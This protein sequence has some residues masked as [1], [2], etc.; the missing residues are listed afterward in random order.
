MYLKEDVVSNEPTLYCRVTPTQMLLQA[1]LMDNAELFDVIAATTE[2]DPRSVEIFLQG[3]DRKQAYLLFE[4]PGRGSYRMFRHLIE[5][6]RFDPTI[7]E[8]DEANCHTVHATEEAG[9]SEPQATLVRDDARGWCCGAVPYPKHTL[10]SWVQSEVGRLEKAL[11]ECKT[12][13]VEEQKRLAVLADVRGCPPPSEVD[14]ALYKETVY[15]SPIDRNRLP[16][17][18][19]GPDRREKYERE[20][21]IR[22]DAAIEYPAQFTVVR[23]WQ[24]KLEALEKTTAGCLSCLEFLKLRLAL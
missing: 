11:M 19:V 23:S 12:R 14:V 21:D 3:S 20:C 18:G 9:C 24:S 13:L 17:L 2:T 15:I 1:A 6:H 10:L 4:L 22:L 5:K 7:K 16:I 8:R